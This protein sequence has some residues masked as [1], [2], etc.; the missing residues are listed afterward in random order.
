MKTVLLTGACGFLGKIIVKELMVDYQLVTMGFQATNQITCN[1]VNEIPQLGKPFDL[2]IHAAGKAHVVPKTKA[3]KQEFFDVNLLGTQNLIKGLEEQE[4]LPKHFVF[5][6]TVAVYGRD[7]GTNIDEN[8]PLDGDTPYALSKIQAEEFLLNW[9]KENGVTIGI[10]RLPLVAAPDPPGNLGDMI[11]AIDNDRYPRIGEANV[12]KSIVWA[13]DVAR[14]LP[15][16]GEH[17]GTYNLTDGI[18]PT[19]RQ[20]DTLIS[21]QLGKKEPFT[22]PYF[23]AK[24]MALVGDLFGKRAPI[25]SNKLRKITLPLTFNDE[26]ARKELDWSPRSVLEQKLVS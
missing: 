3:E 7:H 6:S 24:L 16:I 2:V 5:I 26:K 15:K 22:I 1:L 9:G 19:F 4:H 20:L 21:S 25:N 13:E 8:H 12:Q 23:V 18:H 17:G 10:V 11:Q 14:I